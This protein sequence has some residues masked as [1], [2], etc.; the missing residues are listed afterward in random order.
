MTENDLFIW[1]VVG[2]VLCFLAKFNGVLC[3]IVIIFGAFGFGVNYL[4]SEW[5]KQVEAKKKHEQNLKNRAYN[6]Y[7]NVRVTAYFD[8]KICTQ[9]NGLL[10]KIKNNNNVTIEYVGWKLSVSQPECD[11]CPTKEDE[12]LVS[13]RTLRPQA[14]HVEC[15]HTPV[16]QNDKP[17]HIVFYTIVAKE[18]KPQGE[19]MITNG[20]WR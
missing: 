5:S 16:L 20:S 8:S 3:T 9:Q 18:V 4:Y 6:I 19:K 17:P 14:E 1:L 12:K 2:L 10:V 7:H 15:F 11:G 13:Y